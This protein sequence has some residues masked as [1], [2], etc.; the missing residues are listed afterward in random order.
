MLLLCFNSSISHRVPYVINIDFYVL[1][2]PITLICQLLI[3]VSEW[4]DTEELANACKLTKDRHSVAKT[5]TVN[6]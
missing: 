2:E 1:Y 5:E 6:S 4:P 3:Q